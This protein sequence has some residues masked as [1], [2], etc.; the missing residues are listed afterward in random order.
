MITLKIKYKTTEKGL[1]LIGEYRKQY[2]SVLHYDIML[3]IEDMK[4]LV[5]QMLN[6]K[7]LH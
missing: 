7:Y 4:V 5:K 1:N 6:I 3:I 2:S